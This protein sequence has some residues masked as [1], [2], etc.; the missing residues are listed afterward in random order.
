MVADAPTFSLL[1]EAA[2]LMSFNLSA[3]SSGALLQ[4]RVFGGTL[5]LAIASSV[6]NSHLTSNLSTSIGAQRLSELLQSITAIKGF[7]GNTQEQ[8]LEAFASGYVLQL[9]I[10]AG[11]AFVQVFV[12]GLLLRKQQISVVEQPAV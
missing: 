2:K 8:V 6:M 3:I 10:I 11:F 7:P 5:G 12:V 9:K 4:F 1:I